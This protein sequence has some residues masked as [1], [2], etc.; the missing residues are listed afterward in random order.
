MQPLAVI[1]GR[2]NVGKSTLFNRLIRRNRA[3]THNRPGVTRDRIYGEV[4]SVE[5]GFALV[6][7]GGLVPEP[8][9]KIESEIF[10]QTREAI[11]EADVVLFVVNGREGPAPPDLELAGMLRQSN[12]PVV[13]AV[14]KLDGEE[15]ALAMNTDFYGLGF[16]PLPISA[17]HGYNIP[18]L[19]DS[20]SGLL[21]EKTEPKDREQE[22]GLRIS[23][24]GRPN[25]G[26]SS[27]INTLADEKRQIVHSE[28]GTTRDSVDVTISRNNRMYTFV[29]TAG[30]RRKSRISDS[31]ERFSIL[32]SL[33][34]S[35]RAEVVFL[36]LDALQ[37]VLSQDKKL[38][39][40]LEREKIPFVVLVNKVDQVSKPQ[41][42]KMK[43][44]FQNELRFCPFAPVVYTSAITKAGLGG[45]MPL[46]EKLWNQAR[47][48]VTTGELN[49][50]IREA[51][52]R[53]QPPMVKGRR[54][55]LYYLTQT[56]VNPPEFIFFVNNASLVK[57]AYARYLEKQI[58]KAFGLDMT[59]V[60]MYFRNRDKK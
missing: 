24:L 48:R 7:T 12:K 49:R 42:G 2:P 27:L 59:P 57:P 21:P 54:A 23:L 35:K 1:V 38:L 29:D 3:L 6:D 22:T 45:L 17:E 20:I 15:Q 26:K 43:K 11:E 39:S 52:L 10:D 4:R 9:S 40:F 37:G 55:K 18:E 36:V 30:V 56:D 19:L 16:D 58:R 53:H 31:L 8:E 51:I 41:M 33:K 44:Y 50:L 25:V 34:S 14:N 28:A 46:A 32:R 5:P 47:Q 13:F 60:K